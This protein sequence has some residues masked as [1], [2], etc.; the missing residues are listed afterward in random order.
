[1]VLKVKII[2]GKSNDDENTDTTIN[3]AI[4]GLSVKDIKYSEYT[5]NGEMELTGYTVL[6]MHE[7]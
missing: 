4:S 7:V 6:I 3:K 1:M 5:L 2:R